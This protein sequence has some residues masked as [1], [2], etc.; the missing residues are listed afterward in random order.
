MCVFDL[1]VLCTK[2][3]VDSTKYRHVLELGTRV[4]LRYEIG[5][6]TFVFEVGDYGWFFCM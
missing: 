3:I 1:F 6:H 4:G 2:Y 5:N